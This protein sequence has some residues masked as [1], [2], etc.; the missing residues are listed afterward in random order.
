MINLAQKG[1][2]ISC[3]TLVTGVAALGIGQAVL[4]S[5]AE[6]QRATVQG[7]VFEVDPSGPKLV[8]GRPGSTC[9][10]GVVI[11]ADVGITPRG[12][13]PLHKTGRGAE[14]T[15]PIAECCKAAP[16]VLVFDPAGN[17]V[18]AWGGPGPGYEW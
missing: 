10:S 6:A 8:C 13:R 9:A 16:P 12:P 5:A 2:L 4:Q 15:P 1:K 7:P 11:Q 14:L 3:A 18:R 17:L